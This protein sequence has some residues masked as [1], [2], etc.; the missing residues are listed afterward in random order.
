MFGIFPR[1][2]TSAFHVANIE[3]WHIAR[4]TGPLITEL[5]HSIQAFDY[6][7]LLPKDGMVGFVKTRNVTPAS[8]GVRGIPW[9][10]SCA[11]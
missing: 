10:G 8:A 5:K 6:R 3:R 4:I 2:L 1:K 7:L 9:G 11:S